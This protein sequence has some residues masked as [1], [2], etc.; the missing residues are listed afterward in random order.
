MLSP[1]LGELLERSFNGCGLRFWVRS[2][3]TRFMKF[4][5]SMEQSG[6]AGDGSFV[7]K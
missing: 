3:K 5:G 2:K 7:R 6:G 4:H 1:G